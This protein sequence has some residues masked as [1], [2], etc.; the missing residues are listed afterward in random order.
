M[1]IIYNSVKKN[2][3]DN[4]EKMCKE[5]KRVNREAHLER[6]E[7]VHEYD[8]VI[9]SRLEIANSLQYNLGKK[10]GEIYWLI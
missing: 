8:C 4:S 9:Q 6:M 2:S 1:N 3:G 10:M 5:I 7:W